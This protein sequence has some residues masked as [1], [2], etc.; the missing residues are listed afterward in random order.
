MK[1]L[2]FIV[3]VSLA[4]T[5]AA[6]A[7]IF[8]GGGG[9]SANADHANNIDNGA[10]TNVFLSGIFSGDHAGNFTGKEINLVRDPLGIVANPYPPR[11]NFDY[12]YHFQ[13]GLHSASSRI[14]DS[15]IF[16]ES[17][18]NFGHDVFAP[19]FRGNFVGDGS[20]L[21]GLPTP[22]LT[23]DGSGLTNLTLP[24]PLVSPEFQTPSGA[25]VFN[26]S[27]ERAVFYNAAKSG[28]VALGTGYG[29]NDPC[30]FGEPGTN[31]IPGGE[32]F[33][34]GSNT[35][36]N[37]DF[38][39]SLPSGLTFNGD[40]FIRPDNSGN[41]KEIALGSRVA[42]DLTEKLMTSLLAPVKR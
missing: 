41:A 40:D 22:S 3:V 29:P 4:L 25:S 6:H 21:T 17:G 20:G 39:P 12:T 15:L 7:F 34:I 36:G 32:P 10:G 24:N 26:Y 37:V 31:G 19:N 42:K 2:Q 18:Y 11:I 5:Q 30:L 28:G 8:F 9:S 33:H 38:A 14:T 16:N 35:G 13:V 1:P 23:G 27:S